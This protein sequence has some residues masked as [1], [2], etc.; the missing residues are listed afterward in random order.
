MKTVSTEGAMDG[1][2]TLA[3]ATA[4]TTLVSVFK[5]RGGR[6]ATISR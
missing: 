5:S 3:A 2:A 4:I 1:A 6:R